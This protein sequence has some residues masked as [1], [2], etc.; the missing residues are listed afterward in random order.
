VIF[1]RKDNGSIYFQNFSRKSF[2]HVFEM[3]LGLPSNTGDMEYLVLQKAGVLKPVKLQM[4]RQ[5]NTALVTRSQ[6]VLSKPETC[7]SQE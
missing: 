5:V 6:H 7:L 3:F 4:V 1:L 2:D